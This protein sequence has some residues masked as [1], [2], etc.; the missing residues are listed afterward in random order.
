M[1]Y[2]DPVL[3]QQALGGKSLPFV[4]EPVVSFSARRTQVASNR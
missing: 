2:L 3:V 4:S 1:L